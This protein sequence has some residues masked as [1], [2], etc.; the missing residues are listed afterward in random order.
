MENVEAISEGNSTKSPGTNENTSKVM[1]PPTVLTSEANLICLQSE[2]KSVLSREFLFRKTATGTRVTTKSMMDYNAT[3][4]CLTMKNLHV[5]T[6]YTKADKTVKA[7]IR[8]LP[9]NT[10][11]EDTIVALQEIEYDVISV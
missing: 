1:P 8:H 3:Q 10:S 4:N 2:L 5:F 11:A 7:L 6:F 9:D